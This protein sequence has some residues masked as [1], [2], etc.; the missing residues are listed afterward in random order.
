MKTVILAG[1]IIAACL[2]WADV[3]KQI[4]RY[5]V[6]AYLSG[7]LETV[8][9][10]HLSSLSEGADAEIARLLDAPDPKIADAAKNIL[11]TRLFLYTE[12]SE[13]D[14]GESLT[15]LPTDFRSWNA[16]CSAAAKLL[17]SLYQAGRLAYEP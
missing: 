15:L 3:D 8:D 4:A 2:S 14:S 16:D 5:N 10:A 9:V 11:S 17:W 1:L 6:D 7:K 13:I 12:A